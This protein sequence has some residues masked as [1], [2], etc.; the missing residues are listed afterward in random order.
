MEGRTKLKTALDAVTATTTSEAIDVRGAKKITLMFVRANHS[1]GKTVFTVTASI[2]G[3]T[4]VAYNKLI[5]NV[6][7]SISEGLTRVASYDTGTANAS[8]IYSMDLEHDVIKE[9]KVVA[10]E[11]TDGTHSAYVL[12]QY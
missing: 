1:A 2:D 5:V 12:I 7:N 9:I 3:T 8:A 6:A 4:F 11:T 10:T